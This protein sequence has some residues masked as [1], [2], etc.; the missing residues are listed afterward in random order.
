M[1]EGDEDNRGLRG[2]GFPVTRDKRRGRTVREVNWN[3]K[4][5][6]SHFLK[7]F[8]FYIRELRSLMQ[9]EDVDNLR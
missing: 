8:D 3:N 4:T 2:E 1:V 7:K 9:K 5:G 6:L